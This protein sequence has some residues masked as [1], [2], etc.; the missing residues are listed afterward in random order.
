MLEG[1][2]KY[3]CESCKKKVCAL[4]R[5][6]IQKLPPTLIVHLKR[7]EYVIDRQSNHKLTN[8]FEF[9]MKINMEPYTKEG[10]EK[11]EKGVSG[12]P[13]PD[14]YY[15]SS[16]SFLPGSHPFLMFYF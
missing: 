5:Y 6:S 13:V 1:D 4:K 10:I 11:R 7:F 2:S 9:P 14:G 15:V 12:K 8:H 3:N 16:L